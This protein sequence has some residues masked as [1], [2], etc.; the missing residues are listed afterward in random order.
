MIEKE[1]KNQN[2]EITKILEILEE[3]STATGEKWRAYAYR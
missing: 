2:P 1:K 3:K